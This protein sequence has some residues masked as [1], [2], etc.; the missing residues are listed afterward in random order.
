V[1]RRAFLAL[2]IGLLPSRLRQDKGDL[3]SI[4]RARVL[5]AADGY[6]HEDPVTI[7]ASNSPRSAG[8]AHDYF[9][10]GDY[11]WP[12]P[13]SPN[14]PYI[15]RDGMSNP[16]NFNDHRL[17]LI[18]LSLHVPALTAAWIVTRE[19]RYAAHAVRHLRAWFLDTATRMN[20][21]LLYA[22]AIKGRV[23]GRGTGIIDTLHLVEVARAIS[24]LEGANV[25]SRQ[26]RADVKEWFAKYL[27]WMTTHEYGIQE[28]D[29]KNN[30]ATCWVMQVAEFARL[31][32]NDRVTTF[33]RTRYK[34]VLLPDQMAADGSFPLEIARTKPYGYSLFNLDAMAMICEILSTRQESLWAYQMPDGRGIAKGMEFM[35]PYIADKARWPHKADVMYFDQWPVRQ[36]SL[37]FAGLALNRGEYLDLWRRL[38]PDPTVDEVIRNFVV[39]QPLVWI[40]STDRILVK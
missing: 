35:F 39:R 33:C 28:R 23:T 30:H 37:F 12:D 19:R 29:T 15:Q 38:D 25:M 13:A 8:G 24:V 40:S 9:S 21:H 17:A 7:T 22:Q 2:P 34:A 26:E 6:L 11:W 5:R 36:P 31:T 1:K 20:P 16:G 14:G 27:T 32:G 3:T 10:E 4:E 18:R